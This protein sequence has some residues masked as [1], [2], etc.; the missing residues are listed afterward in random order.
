MRKWIAIVLIIIV[1]VTAGVYFLVF[2]KSDRYTVVQGIPEDAVF[3]V[4]TASF[5]GIHEHLR[6]NKVWASLKTYPYFEEYH[7]NMAYVDSLCD[8]YPAIKRLVIDRPFAIS[9]H[10]LSSTTYDFLYVCDLGKLNVIRVFESA[11]GKLIEDDHIRIRRKGEITELVHDDIKIYYAIKANLLCISLTESL[12]KRSLDAVVQA[13]KVERNISRGDLTI[14]FDH[15]K[16]G[17]WING[18]LA[19]PSSGGDT[20]MFD[21]TSL[22]L[23]VSDKGLHCTGETTLNRER[24][25]LLSALNLMNGGNSTVKNIA[26]DNIAGYV[27]ICFDSFTE[28]ENI[29]M[30]NYK[31]HD[32]KTYQQYEQNLNKI[33]KYLGLDVM[34]SFTSWIGNEI[35]ILKPAVDREKGVDHVVFAIRSKDVLEAKDQMRY[36]TEQIERKTPVRFKVIEYNGHTI[37]FLSLKGFFNLFLGSMF[38]KLERPYYTFIE[39]YVVFSNSPATLA[40]MI[41]T[42]S[43]GN[44]LVNNEKYNQLMGQLG[45]RNSVYGYVNT[46][47]MYHYMDELLVS[48]KRVELAKNKGAFLSFETIGFALVNS[49]SMFE[50]Q[51]I[52]DYDVN[53]PEE[54][55]I[56]TLNRE[57]EDL[58]DEIESGYY[59]P[60]IPDSIAISTKGSYAYQ[61]DR[62]FYSGMLSNGDLIGI[63]E[64]RDKQ[65][66]LLG[67][68]SYRENR[69]DG[70]TRF[71]HENGTVMAQIS[72]DK[73]EVSSYKEYFPDGTLKMEM[74]YNKGLRHGDV[75]FY[76]STGHLFGEGKYRK[77]RRSGIWKYYKVTGEVDKKNKF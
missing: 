26:G 31:L 32:L 39:D 54:Y 56:K 50:T 70:E 41:K 40:D 12:V 17:K 73:G 67:Q 22:L 34:K 38:N 64:I 13:P 42:Y 6:R 4:E 33:N 71:F 48:D 1:L 10:M 49:G 27:S 53:A 20:S 9:C 77:G 25:S 35:A 43:L 19:T 57:L 58:A 45:S 61:T 44:T 76:Y 8:A 24:F 69:P 63:W 65:G 55:E 74:E 51:I 66:R 14:D 62:L 59:L 46:H 47:N 2:H 11:L 75:R 30:E 29:L 36:L 52:A 68:Y 15:R 72:Y 5:N 7:A 60:V 18:I 23:K 37:N 3:V 21:K 16:V 28:L